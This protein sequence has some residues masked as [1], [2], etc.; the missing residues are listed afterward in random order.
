MRK[1]VS[2]EVVSVRYMDGSEETTVINSEGV[3]NPDTG[4]LMYK[5]QEEGSL[6]AVVIHLFGNITVKMSGSINSEM[7]F[8]KEKV[9][10]GLYTTPFGRHDIIIRTHEAE[11]VRDE[12]AE[13][14]AL[15]YSLTLGGQDLG[16]TRMKIKAT[17]I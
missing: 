2:V 11:H 16:E 8:D 4:L 12:G 5:T 9:T 6:T 3:Y 7:I 13:S 17:Y 15:R 1:K 10:A 14:I